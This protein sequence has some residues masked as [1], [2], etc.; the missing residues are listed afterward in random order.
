MCC[1]RGS[2]PNPHLPAPLQ[3]EQHNEHIAMDAARDKM[4]AMAER[5]RKLK[6]MKRGRSI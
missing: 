5:E 2:F 3:T 4:M 1:I 6:A